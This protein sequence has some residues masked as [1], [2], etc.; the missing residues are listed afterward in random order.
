MARV[1]KT[2]RNKGTV[3]STKSKQEVEQESLVPY[4][5]RVKLLQEALVS[6][7]DYR[8]ELELSKEIG[9]SIQQIRRL[10]SNPD[11]YNPLADEFKRKL[12]STLIDTVKAMMREVD[13]GSV[14]AAKVM[15]QLQG[16]IGGDGVTVNI[17]NNQGGPSVAT[18]AA[19]LTPVEL[20]QEITR[21][22]TEVYPADL[23]FDAEGFAIEDAED[24]RYEVL[25]SKETEPSPGSGDSETLPDG[26]GS[27][28]SPLH[29][30]D[31]EAE[32]TGV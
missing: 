21:L 18:L 12:P 28:G 9:L 4:E 7:T 13:K 26:E 1:V 29:D 14:S 2:T 30:V 20:D 19:Q 8:T 10:K 15:L 6:P 23:S 32:A 5:D 3:L 24:A 17:T 11:F 27:E 25:D 16:L 22:L 31:G